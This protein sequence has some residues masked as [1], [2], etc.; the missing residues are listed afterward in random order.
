MQ[1]ASLFATIPLKNNDTYY[2]HLDFVA[3]IKGI[4]KTSH[5]F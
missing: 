2:W 3:W 5:A 4:I 1:A